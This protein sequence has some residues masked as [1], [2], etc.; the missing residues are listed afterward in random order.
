MDIEWQPWK[1]GCTLYDLVSALC[2]YK[3][4]FF[5]LKKNSLLLKKQVDMTRKYNN[6]RLQTNSPWRKETQNTDSPHDSNNT[7]KVKQPEARSTRQTLTGPRLLFWYLSLFIMCKVWHQYNEPPWAL[8]LLKTCLLSLFLNEMI[9][10]LRKD[11][12]T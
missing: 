8:V 3:C 6:H 1:R 9:A 12:K 7:I 5:F 11:Y 10:K 2:A 4:F